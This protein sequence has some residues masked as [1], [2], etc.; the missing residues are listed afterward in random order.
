MIEGAA[1]MTTNL[2]E[3]IRQ[4]PEFQAG[5]AAGKAIVSA[6]LARIDTGEIDGSEAGGTALMNLV[7]DEINRFPRCDESVLTGASL[8]AVARFMGFFEALGAALHG[9]REGQP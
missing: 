6:F 5:H 8:F 4:R 7:L 3:C 1:M 9:A 2:L